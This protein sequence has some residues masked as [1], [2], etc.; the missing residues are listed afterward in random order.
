MLLVHAMFFEIVS[1]RICTVHKGQL[2]NSSSNVVQMLLNC[3]MGV[4]LLMCRVI[5]AV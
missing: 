1:L 5:K 4:V 2:Q 3:S